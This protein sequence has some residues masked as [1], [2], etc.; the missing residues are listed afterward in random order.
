MKIGQRM[1]RFG[2]KKLSIGVVSVA[3]G[4][5]FLAPTGISANEGSPVVQNETPVVVNETDGPTKLENT[6]KKQERPLIEERVAVIQPTPET[7]EVL[8]NQKEEEKLESH[9]T[10][11]ALV[12]EEVNK[13][14]NLKD[15]STTSRPVTAEDL[16]KISKGELH[17]E[18]DLLDN[19]LY[20]EKVLDLEGDDDQDGIK[21]KDELYVYRKDGKDY[22][23]YNSHPLLADSDGDG[24]ADGEDDNKK[25]WYVTDRDALLFMELSYRDDDYIEK[26]L[27]HKNPFPSL[28]LNRQEYKM[29]HNELAPFWKMKK[30]YHT[31]SGM[32]AFLFETK[33]DL[34]YLKDNTVQMLAIRGTR[35]ND[36][37]DLSA[38][39]V[40]F[41]GNKPAQADDIRDVVKELTQDS[42][43]TNLYMTGH[44]LG[45]Y[46]AQIA[47]VEAYQKYPTF[48]NN[49]LKKVT[50]F[51]APKVITSRT[52]WNAKNGFWDVGLESRKLAV[53]GKIKHYVVDNDNVVTPLIHNDRDIV[54]FTG[55]SSFRHRSRGY[56]E[57]RM[58]A[59]PNF[60]IG[61]RDTLDKQG[62]RDPKLDKV[63]F[64]KKQQ[65]PLSSSQPSAESLE[66]IALGKRVTQSSTAF[67][68]DARRA[69]DGKLDGN[70]G[71]NSVTHTDFQ[72]KPW[73]QVDLDK[74]ETIR[75]IN[76]YNRTDAAQD[77]LTNFNVILLDSSGKEIERK[78]IA[79]LRDS[80]AQISIDYKKARFVRIELDGYNA[81]SLAEVQVFRAENIAWKKQARQSSTDFGGDASRALD[82]NTNS[83][84]SQQSITHTKFE[85]QPWWEV[86]LGR[87]EQVGLV[88]LHNRGDGELS[89]R[90]SDFDVILYDEKGTEVARQYVSRL[91]GS[92]LDLQLNGKLGRRVR[93]QL[94][95]KNQALSLA[96]VEV[97]RFVAKNNVTAQ[98]SKPVQLL[99][100]TPVKD[101]N[102]TIQ[103]SGAYIARYSISW[104]EV[105]VDKDGNSVVRSRSWEGNGR[106]QT[107]GSI[108][109]L[110]IKSNMR[111]LRIK[112]E[113]RTGLIWNRW[114]TIYD[115]IP[116]LAQP[117]R[118]ITHWGTTLNSKV[119]D[120]DVL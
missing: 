58:N 79:Y 117:H 92:S 12:P 57:S 55:N 43:I 3:V 88:R 22:L 17:S 6:D 100:Y 68:G 107:A 66:N 115:N 37:K 72:S 30:A 52:I 38:D 29:M 81:L 75:Q 18:N 15:E 8:K 113:K 106:N 32:D 11:P 111:N 5:A 86:D 44:S 120:D 96:E 39:F 13:E 56:F 69:V 50:T 105:T 118:K 101:K 74:E 71:H 23:G 114:Q 28:Y 94:R 27:D 4:F 85:N 99:N 90:L 112:I 1:M 78:R 65:V 25:Q 60:N 59:I 2:I 108:L 70:Y 89:K 26:I 61:K 21:N 83:S 109:N 19:S 36:A 76:I 64:F 63:Y 48:Y 98:A 82:G 54:T 97:F 35:L 102:L 31:A 46:L 104:E 67:G 49:V 62:Y 7:K 116:L 41:G 53:S 47:A 87:T 14:E 45:G 77:R 91:E 95:Q 119:S 34:P 42:T 20:G 40:L 80:S 73:W 10:E 51:S 93:I 9:K 16:L 110:P 84:Y 103:H 24:L 33:S